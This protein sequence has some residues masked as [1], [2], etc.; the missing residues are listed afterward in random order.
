MNFTLNNLQNSLC[1]TIKI[2]DSGTRGLNLNLTLEYAS[3]EYYTGLEISLNVNFLF[4]WVLH[5]HIYFLLCQCA[6]VLC[7]HMFMLVYVCLC[8]HACERL[9]ENLAHVLLA[10]STLNF[11]FDT[12]SVTGLECSKWT[13]KIQGSLPLPH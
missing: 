8:A 1:S 10:Q 11:F 12:L 4:C 5:Y 7:V 2:L 3:Y 6:C 9:E 13:S